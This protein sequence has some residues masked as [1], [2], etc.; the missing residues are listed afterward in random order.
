VR[1]I[2]REGQPRV[3]RN[4]D[5]YSMILSG[6]RWKSGAFVRELKRRVATVDY[7]V[8]DPSGEPD[9]VDRDVTPEEISMEIQGAL[10]FGQLG[11]VLLRGD[12]LF[13]GRKSWPIAECSATVEAAPAGD[14]K[15]ERSEAR[16]VV[17][18]KDE[19]VI[20]DVRSGS[21]V[22]ARQLAARINF[23]AEEYRKFPV[24]SA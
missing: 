12:T 21:E 9:Q 7:E 19:T 6:S 1:V 18:T 14:E 11:K 22:Q 10:Q 20:A 24:G 3:H 13:N 15:S 23:A 17:E 4:I 8:P 16:L 2:T 5:S